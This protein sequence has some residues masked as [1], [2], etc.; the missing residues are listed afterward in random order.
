MPRP[1]PPPVNNGGHPPYRNLDGT[2][3]NIA[4]GR[5]EWGA[6]DIPLLRELPVEYGN[7]DPKN[8]MGGAHRPSA[9][10]LSNVL[11][12]EPTTIFSGRNLST[13]IYVW[14]QFLDHDITL[15]PTG[16]TEYAPVPLPAD[17]PLFTV[18][19]PFFRS[20]VR[21]GTGVNNPRQQSNLNTA[22][23]DASVVYGSDATRANWLRTFK[24]GKL[25]T[26]AGNLLPWNTTTGEQT[27]PIDSTAP[28]MVNDADHTVKTFVA[29]DVRAGEHPG[30]T[31]LHTLF[32]R[33]H[34]RICD[35]LLAQGLRNDEEIYQRA[36]KE[37]G[38]LIQAITYQEFLPIMGVTLSPYNGYR[39]NVQPDLLNTF[40]TAAYRIGH[41]MVADEIAMRD[42][43]CNKVGS[44]VLELDEVF[45]DPQFIATYGLEPFLKGFAGH[46]MYETNTKI[47]S[48]LRNFLFGSPSAPVRFGLDLASLNIQRGRDHGLPNYN[49]IRAFY[50]G[51]PIRDFNQITTNTT[52]AMA[53]KNLYGNV[54]NIDL[55]IG[56]LAEDLLPGKSVGPTMHAMLKTQ[57]ERLRD[58]DF[59]FFRND[60]ALPQNIR[61]QVSNT[62]LSDVIKRNTSLT[63]LPDNVFLTTPCPGENGEAA[64][65]A[66]EVAT[67]ELKLNL[68][69]NPTQ[70]VLTIE[71][72]THPTTRLLRIVGLDGSLM[73]Q[74]EV[75]AG[76]TQL[77]VP[78][79]E[80][81]AGL[82]LVKLSSATTIKTVRFIKAGH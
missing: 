18:P 70:Q 46:K 9:R 59:Y 10:Q 81:R 32:V 60:P 14:G 49:A 36:R 54:N 13:F 20:E 22:W 44:G 19:V 47:N 37:V 6:T 82:Y 58:G 16:S 75:A 53:L 56:L 79:G 17:E 48:V 73:K 28:S 52:L 71:V 74:L 41:T 38:A 23:V 78:V 43:N 57:F 68:Y 21:T 40:A 4:P 45:F 65:V 42:N 27:A 2:N 12:D 62:K 8:A 67:S 11:C 39:D 51:N 26:S 7:S 76:T 77:S 33:E 34:N 30:I 66:T 25:K 15:T 69:P 64:R 72:D 3:N 80:L 55:W 35:R 1:A 5:S 63:N 31:G 24:N 61:D 50:T 29:G